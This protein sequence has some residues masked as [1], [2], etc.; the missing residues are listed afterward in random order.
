MY[1][2]YVNNFRISKIVSRKKLILTQ[3]PKMVREMLVEIILIICSVIYKKSEIVIC[4]IFITTSE[5]LTLFIRNVPF[6]FLRQDTSN[7]YKYGP[8]FHI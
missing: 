4:E 8:Q 6:N 2:V 7:N 5:C 1:V 3:A